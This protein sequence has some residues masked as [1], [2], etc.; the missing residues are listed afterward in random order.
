LAARSLLKS[1][2]ANIRMLPPS[3]SAWC[4]YVG[5]RTGDL[6]DRGARR[7]ARHAHR[8]SATLRTIEGERSGPDL[9]AG[10]GSRCAVDLP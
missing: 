7:H 6:A 4:S 2:E 5:C 9:A 1:E 3:S 8:S 10:A